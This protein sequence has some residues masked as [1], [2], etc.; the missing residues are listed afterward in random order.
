MNAVTFQKNSIAKA[1]TTALL[2]SAPVTHV[3]AQQ[4]PAQD[5][6]TI[7]RI[8]VNASRRTQ[9]IQDVPYNISA[10]SGSEL[11]GKYH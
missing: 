10:I 11:Q 4:S 9:S 5:E 8:E 1:I 2:L 3:S 7:E 6:K